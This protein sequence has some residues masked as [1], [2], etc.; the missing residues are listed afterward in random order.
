MLKAFGKVWS[1][2]MM[3]NISVASYEEYDNMTP[4]ERKDTL[5]SYIELERQM[6][7]LMK[8]Y[9]KEM[10]ELR[11]TLEELKK[12]LEEVMPLLEELGDELE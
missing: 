3:S 10:D 4:T 6:T 7:P 8:A 9:E 1:V 11:P 2:T 12:E 5:I